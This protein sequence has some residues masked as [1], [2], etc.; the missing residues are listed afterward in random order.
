MSS[1]NSERPGILILSHGPLCQAI[2]D[3]ARMIAGDVGGVVGLPLEPGCDVSEYGDRA[4]E[5]LDGMPAGSIVLFDLFAGTPFNQLAARFR[6][7]PFLALCG[8]NLPMLL[9]A[10]SMRENL[11]GEDLL[12]AIAESARESIVNVSDF[13]ADIGT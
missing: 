6:S 8:V 10:N 2:I 12:R 9:D 1:V 5:I 13:I 3:S 7:H 11:S 4:L